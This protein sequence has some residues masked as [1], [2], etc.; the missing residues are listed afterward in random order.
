[1]GAL[2]GVW[3]IKES[4][5]GGMGRKGQALGAV[6]RKRQ[7]LLLLDCETLSRGRLKGDSECTN[8]ADLTQEG[9]EAG[10]SGEEAFRDELI[11]ILSDSRR[12]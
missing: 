3:L 5:K 8:L 2:G 10:R 6:L 4:V 12:T 9:G 7:T 11:K 1:M